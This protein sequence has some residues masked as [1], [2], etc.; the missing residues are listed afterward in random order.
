MRPVITIRKKGWIIGSAFVVAGWIVFAFVFYQELFVSRGINV[1]FWWID[2]SLRYTLLTVLFVISLICYVAMRS[3]IR[4]FLF[5]IIIFIL[6]V[7]FGFAIGTRITMQPNAQ[8]LDQIYLNGHLYHLVIGSTS[9]QSSNSFGTY[10]TDLAIT[11]LFRCDPL[12]IQCENLWSDQTDQ[13]NLPWEEPVI[14]L[15]QS[16]NT[17]YV[18]GRD[19]VIYSHKG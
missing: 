9:L 13:Y 4:H 1:R 14:S 2:D 12:H 8:P 17:I 10:S 7:G 5:Q 15:Y 3:R 16:D 11:A 18:I 19:S 6:L